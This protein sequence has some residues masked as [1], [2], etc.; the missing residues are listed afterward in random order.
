MEETIVAVSSAPGY[1][2]LGVVRISGPEAISIAAKISEMKE[3]KCLADVA[4]F[5]RVRGEI[6]AALDAKLPAFFHVFRAPK[7]YTGQDMIEMVSIG[8][9]PILAL[10]RERLIDEGARHAEPGEFTLRAFINGRLDVQAAQGVAGLIRARSDVQLR[11]SRRMMDATWARE[12]AGLRNEI[13]ELL[14]LVEADID[15]AEEPIEFITPQSLA[16]SLVRIGG[17]LE[18]LQNRTTTI[19]RFGIMPHVLLLGPPNAGKSSLMNVLSKTSRA[20]CSAVKGTTRDILSAPVALEGGEVILLDSAGIDS[21]PDDVLRRARELALTTAENVD[22]LCLVLDA[23]E[24]ANDADYLPTFL[25]KLEDI[26]LPPSVVA[27]NKCELL[28]GDEWEKVHA[29]V[30]SSGHVSA[31]AVSARTGEGLET[32]RRGIWNTLGTEATAG[33]EMLVL[34]ESQ[35][36]AI[37][38]ARNAIERAAQLSSG[39]AETVDRADVIAFE[40]REA[41]DRMG[42]VTGGVLTEDLLGHIFAH[43]CIGK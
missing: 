36:S 35:R 22:A 27:C 42:N 13:A 1:G 10:V 26:S 3:G 4:G 37:A 39:A 8:A 11:A 34:D 16:E 31:I 2:G 40:L 41:V 6:C 14:A 43:F 25:A 23:P 29:Q 9:P 33:G 5:Q 28:S 32:L 20:I 21:N 19:E 18:V 24:C 38:E 30:S 7:S 15:F 17:K 12:I